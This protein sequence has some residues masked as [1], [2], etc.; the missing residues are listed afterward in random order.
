MSALTVLLALLPI[1][2]L[3][4]ALSIL[5]L[6]AWKATSVAAI[7]SFIVAITYFQ[8]D[9]MIMLSGA[10]EGAALAIWPILLVIT[11]A[12]FVYN[13]VVHTKAMETI[14]TMLSS[15][16][17]D[18]RVLALLLAW[19]FGA[20]MEGMAG[21]GTAVAIPAAMMVA[22]GFDPLKSIIACLVANSVPTTY[23]SIGIPTTTLASLTGLDPVHLGTFIAVQLFLLNL[24]APFF[25]VMIIGGGFKALKGVFLV[26]FLSGLALAVPEVIINKLLGPELS[27]ISASI[28]IMAVI[29]LCAKFLPPNDPAYQ[30]KQADAPKVS[31]SE[32]VIA[33]MP[34]ILIFV[35]LL[36]TSKLF[37]AINGP[38]AS[39]KTSVPIYQGEGAKPYTFVWIATPGIMIFI[40]GILGGFIQKASAGEIFGTLGSTVKNLKFTYLTIITVVMTAKLMTYSGM[41]I[42]IANALVAATGTMYPAFSPIVGALGAFL[43]GSGTNSN[44][45]FG[46]LQIASAQ[47]LDPANWE[48]L[49]FWL[50]A[51]NSGAAGIGKMLSPQS[52][53]ISIG[54]VGPALKAYLDSHKEITPEEAHK[55][56]HEVEANVIMNS[57][58]KY[59]LIFIIMHGAIAFFGQNYIHV[60]HKV[61]F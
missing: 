23:G 15:V 54:A 6:P 59:F 48:D 57:A 50:A 30:V 53:A 58:F 40:A 8:A 29:I 13:L 51:V 56:E 46:P 49:G 9:P 39:I 42:E 2:W 27:V 10:L 36:L 16:T 41:T 20:F 47:S 33:A 55:L 18:M 61:F 35:L 17:S 26:T 34:F 21:F 5:K 19:G 45:L 24:I 4:V 3:I 25:V 7:G 60:I 37:P 31:G 44:V 38:L 32:G 14:K 22:V 52:I 12:I 43:T 11:A 1:I 28:A